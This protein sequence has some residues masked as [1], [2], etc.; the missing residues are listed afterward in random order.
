MRITVLGAILIVAA[1]AAG[2]YLVFVLTEN[3]TQRETSS[4]PGP[5]RDQNVN[6]DQVDFGGNGFL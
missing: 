5:R 4:N 3:E 2:L 1:V 6:P